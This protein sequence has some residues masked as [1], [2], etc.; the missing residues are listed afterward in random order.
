MCEGEGMVAAQL[1]K[2]EIS[3]VERSPLGMEGAS[4]GVGGGSRER[5]SAEHRGCGGDA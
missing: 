1:G 4:I 5:F 2:V 3:T